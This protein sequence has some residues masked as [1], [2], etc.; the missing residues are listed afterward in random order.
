M[1]PSAVRSGASWHMSSPTST[2]PERDPPLRRRSRQSR[3]MKESEGSAKPAEPTARSVF[4]AR[5]ACP[6]R[7]R[8]SRASSVCCA[9]GREQ[10]DGRER[11][12]LTL[13]VWAGVSEHE[14]IRE[15]AKVLLPAYRRTTLCG[16]LQDLRKLAQTTRSFPGTASSLRTRRS[17]HS[18]AALR[19]PS[20]APRRSAERNP[21][22]PGEAR[23]AAR[24]G[25]ALGARAGRASRGLGGPFSSRLLSGRGGLDAGG[26]VVGAASGERSCVE[27]SEAEDR[28]A[29]AVRAAAD[30]LDVLERARSR[31]R[32][33]PR[34][35]PALK[36]ASK[37][38]T[39]AP[40]RGR[41]R[42]RAERR[43]PALPRGRSACLGRR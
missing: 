33:R 24:N 16:S 29:V 4:A 20:Q 2:S 37:S 21:L 32:I 23:L 34:I 8:S 22:A 13:A 27:R 26:R 15:A 14:R 28:A 43:R 19:R 25:M 1:L 17:T 31:T 6:G 3:R 18:A 7:C 42:P 39:A 30:G 41:G 36:A 10:L 5:G 35:W 12:S 40:P 38:S 9:S 11:P